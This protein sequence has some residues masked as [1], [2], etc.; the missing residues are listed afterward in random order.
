MS[1]EWS[2]Q[3][4]TCLLQRAEPGRGTGLVLLLVA[5]LTIKGAVCVN[6]DGGTEVNNHSLVCFLPVK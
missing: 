5:D 1:S 2:Q 6:T 3:G 4:D